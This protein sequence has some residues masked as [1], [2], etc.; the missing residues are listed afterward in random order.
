[1]DDLEVMNTAILGHA[2]SSLLKPGRRY[3][4][5]IDFTNDP[6]YGTVITENEKRIAKNLCYPV[7]ERHDS[8]LL[9]SS[10]FLHSMGGNERNASIRDDRDKLIGIRGNWQVSNSFRVKKKS[11]C[12]RRSV[13][14]RPGKNNHI[15]RK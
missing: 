5:A 7:N 15:G 9:N 14:G 11:P 1:M 2:F 3:I 8:I 10:P 4:L 6:D 13:C 12:N